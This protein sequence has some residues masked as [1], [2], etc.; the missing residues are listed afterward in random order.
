MG[1]TIT[2][3]KN[4]KNKGAN[5]NINKEERL[6]EWAAQN[7]Y[8]TDAV[9]LNWLAEHNGSCSVAPVSGGIY[10]EK[11]LDGSGVKYY[12]FMFQAIFALSDTTDGVNTRN[13]FALRQWQDWIDEMENTGN[14]PDFGESCGDYELQNLANAP[15][16]AQVY[17]NGMAKYQFPARLI[18]TEG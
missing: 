1:K 7:P 18:Y 16:L 6:I 8:L 5:I 12:D 2:K 14:Y 11:Y 17:N 13:M 10:A 4:K 3:T 9:K 15:Q